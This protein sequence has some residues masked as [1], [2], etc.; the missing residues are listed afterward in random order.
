MYMWQLKEKTTQ[1][2]RLI[3]E[4]KRCNSFHTTKGT[5][6]SSIGSANQL[7]ELFDHGCD[8]ISI[9]LVLMSGASAVGLADYPWSLLVFI[10]LLVHVNFVYH[11]QTYVCG[12]LHFNMYV[13]HCDMCGG[14]E[15][16]IIVTVF[17]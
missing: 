14:G 8:A 17:A 12:S 16:P 1:N 15:T 3:S 9:Y 6:L 13:S 2:R 10:V 11:W 7:G 5:L 4:E